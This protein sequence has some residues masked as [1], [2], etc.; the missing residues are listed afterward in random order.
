MAATF[1]DHF[2]FQLLTALNLILGVSQVQ[3]LLDQEGLAAQNCAAKYASSKDSPDSGSDVV[4]S[5]C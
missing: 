4:K 5:V 1:T 2:A 3:L